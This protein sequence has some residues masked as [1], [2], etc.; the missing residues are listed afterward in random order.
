MDRLAAM[1]AFTRA[2]ERGSFSA[3]ARELGM[4]Q[5]TLSRLIAALERRLG[6]KLFTRSGRALAV[7]PEGRRFYAECRLIVQAAHDA[8]SSFGAARTEVAGDLRVA[9][10]VSFGRELLVSRM[11]AF[12]ARYPRLCVDLQLSDGFV[13]LVGEGI[14]L[15]FRVGVLTDDGVIARRV[16]TAHRVSV[17]APAYL[18]RRGTPRRAEDLAHHDCILYTGLA[19]GPV[20]PYRRAGQVVNV[21][22]AGRFRSNSSEAVRAATVAGLG[23]ALSPAWLFADDLKAGRVVPLLPDHIPEPLPIHAICPPDRRA[24]RKITACVEFFHDAFAQDPR[25]AA[26]RPP[27]LSA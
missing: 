13:S 5:P 11:P 7:T 9:S 3:A 2:V 10:P 23:I 24:S 6:G 4:Q 1:T 22:V 18:R 25:V 8:E 27:Q 19:T 21:P 17:A 20:W 16:G 15:A 12:L 14:D 26:S